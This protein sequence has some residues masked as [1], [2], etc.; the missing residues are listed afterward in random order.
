M[1]TKNI[2]SKIS[3]VWCIVD[4]FSYTNIFMCTCLLYKSYRC[5]AVK[6]QRRGENESV[7]EANTV[8][9]VCTLEG[10]KPGSEYL[11]SVRAI[12]SVSASAAAQ[13]TLLM[14]GAGQCCTWYSSIVARLQTFVFKIN[15][16]ML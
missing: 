10:L 8:A 13:V 2:C 11:L 16:S 3:Y 7:V 5:S 9:T 15:I 1:H 6:I 12:N 4:L 14:P